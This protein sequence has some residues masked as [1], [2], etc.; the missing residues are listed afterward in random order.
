MIKRKFRMSS[1]FGLTAIVNLISIAS[2]ANV[3]P[4]PDR[5]KPANTCAEAIANL[6]IAAER[7]PLISVQQQ[8][9][10]LKSAV[11]RVD[12]LCGPDKGYK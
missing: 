4:N 7:N 10:R 8:D 2:W 12:E 9:G 1:F 3:P 5:A 6:K 11:A